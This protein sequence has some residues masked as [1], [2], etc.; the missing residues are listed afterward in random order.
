MD[1]GHEFISFDV[2]EE[3]YCLDIKS[4]REIRGWSKTTPLPH[5][6]VAVR[7]VINLRGAIMPVVDLRARLGQGLTEASDRHVIIVVHAD[8]SMFGLLVDAVQETLV[9]RSDEIQPPP[10]FAERSLVDGIIARPSGLLSRLSPDL[11]AP[12]AIAAMADAA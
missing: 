9:V 10:E 8:D 3:A 2:G 11:L 12:S 5:S 4:V 7:G 1:E 6:P